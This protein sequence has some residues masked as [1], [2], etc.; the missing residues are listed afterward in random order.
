MSSAEGSDRMAWP[1]AG[2]FL[3]A[4]PNAPP[5]T[6]PRTLGILSINSPSPFSHTGKLGSHVGRGLPCCNEE[7]ASLIKRG[8]YC[9]DVRQGMGRENPALR[10]LPPRLR[11]NTRSPGAEPTAP[12]LHTPSPV[13][14]WMRLPPLHMLMST[15]QES[16]TPSWS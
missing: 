1:A 16:E 2:P 10:P 6:E 14:G 4:N 13:G 5:L 8:H 12:Q 15:S 9:G 11:G 7:S 3:P